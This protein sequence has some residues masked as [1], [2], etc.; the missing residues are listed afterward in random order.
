MSVYQNYDTDE[1]DKFVGFPALQWMSASV[2]PVEHILRLIA[3]NEINRFYFHVSDQKEF[4][5]KLLA[6]AGI[7]STSNHCFV[8]G[9]VP[10]SKDKLYN[11]VLQFYPDI[12]Y[13]DCDFF[14]ERASEEEITDMAKSSGLYED[15][16]DI[17]ALV[18]DFKKKY[19]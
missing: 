4:Q 5:T 9:C 8:K 12:D 19:K 11:L 1:L 18:K 16:K 13:E 17:T 2:D 15:K 10:K 14:L 6:S 7:N 3:T